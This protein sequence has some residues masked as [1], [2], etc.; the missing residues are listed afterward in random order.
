MTKTTIA[1]VPYSTGGTADAIR[2]IMGG[3]VHAVIDGWAGLRG[4]LKSGDLTALAIMSPK[5]TA[6]CPTCR[7]HRQPFPVSCP[8]AGRR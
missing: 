6:T 7:S 8:S 1:V 4:A 2:D 5:P 3:R